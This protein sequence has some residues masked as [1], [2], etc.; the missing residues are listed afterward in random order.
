MFEAKD[1][2]LDLKGVRVVE[3]FID[4]FPKELSGDQSL[5]H[6]IFHMIFV[7]FN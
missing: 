2:P 5:F 4:V 6:L 1:K 3:D 7:A